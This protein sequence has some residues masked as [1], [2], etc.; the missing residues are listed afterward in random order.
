MEGIGG[1]RRMETKQRGGTA[2]G[3]EE[4]TRVRERVVI[5]YDAVIRVLS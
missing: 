2:I 5:L 1:G 3:T 4:N